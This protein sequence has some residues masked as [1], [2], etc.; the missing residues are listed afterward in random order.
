M[1]RRYSE[2]QIIGL[3]KRHERGEKMADLCRELGI[4]NQTFYAWKKKFGGMEVSEAKRMRALEIEN[5]KLKR[6]VADLALDNQI[7]K[8]VN[9]KKW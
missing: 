2:E 1:K 5:G 6:L 4:A 7:L 9:S 8:E 3:L